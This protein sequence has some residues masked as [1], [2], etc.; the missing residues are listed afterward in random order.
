M[1]IIYHSDAKW[2]RTLGILSL[3]KYPTS[4]LFLCV[5]NLP[6][7]E[8]A[9]DMPKRAKELPMTVPEVRPLIWVTKPLTWVNQSC[10]REIGQTHEIMCFVH[11]P[12]CTCTQKNHGFIN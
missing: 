11:P 5:T 4:K 10:G 3:G 1:T 8:V 2:H 9:S 6:R 12:T 7:V